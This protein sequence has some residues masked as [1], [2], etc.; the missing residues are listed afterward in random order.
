M[1]RR[2]LTAL[3]LSSMLIPLPALAQNGGTEA[4]QEACTPDVFKLCQ[5]DI[6]NEAPI[7]ACLKANR[8]QLSPACS[9]VMF[10]VPAVAPGGAVV[11][12][13]R[14]HHRHN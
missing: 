5:D 3:V 14:R 13:H 4:E 10:P 11:R 1:I 8:A 7:V 2:S 12:H 9:L 6:P